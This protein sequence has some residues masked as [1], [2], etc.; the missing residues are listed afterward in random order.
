MVW[1]SSGDG[2]AAFWQAATQPQALA[3][4]RLTF[5]VAAL[6]AAGNAVMGT[7]VAW[8]LVRDRFPGQRVVDALIDL[9][10]ALPTIVAGIT[11][12]ACTAAPAR[13]GST[14]ATAA[15]GS[16]SPWPS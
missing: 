1:R 7:V 3:A 13:S 11:L 5:A 16:C 9:P 6:V 14:S 12:L 15:P 8:V 10:F 2:W 4:L